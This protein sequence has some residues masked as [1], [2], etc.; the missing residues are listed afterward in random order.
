MVLKADTSAKVR[1]ILV[2]G[3][4]GFIGSHLVNQLSDGAHDIRIYSRLKE[5]QSFKKIVSEE[6]W[7]VGHL[8][9]QAALF[10]ACDGVETTYHAAGLASSDTPNAEQLTR[11]NF[12]GTAEVYKACVL[13]GVKNFVYFSS[14]HAGSPSSSGYAKSKSEAEKFLISQCKTNRYPRV[15]ILRSANVYGEGMQGKI[16][17]FIYYANLGVI[18]SLPKLDYSFSMVSVE[19]LC[20]VAVALANRESTNRTICHT[21]TDG[22]AYTL[23]RVESAIY[24]SLGRKVP[25]IRITR[26]L[27]KCLSTVAR[28]LNNTGILYNTIGGLSDQLLSG[29]SN[30]DTSESFP[31]YHFSSNVTFESKLPTI[32]AAMKRV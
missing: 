1:T 32:V 14:V 25:R 30:A 22:E 15:I 2:T 4:T 18:P 23:N 5:R 31:R 9:D 24:R 8:N 7:I 13:A 17:R 16:G 3:A 10:K 26:S 21:V 20:S 27:V 6:N 11:V 12:I 28:V 29:H 19:D